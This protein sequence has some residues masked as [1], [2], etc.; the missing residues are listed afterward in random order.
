MLVNDRREYSWHVVRL[1]YWWWF[2]N[3]DLEKSPLE[4]NVFIWETEAG[5]I[6]A[7]LNPEGHGQAFLQTHPD[8]H[9]PELGEQMIVAAEEHLTTTGEDGHQVL[10]FFIDSQDKVRKSCPPASTRR[11]ARNQEY[12]HR[13]C[14]MTARTAGPVAPSVHERA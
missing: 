11:S 14:W 12:Q 10:S 2:A 13:R 9:S 3:P 1:D 6:A 8:F 4:E 5:Q 7:V